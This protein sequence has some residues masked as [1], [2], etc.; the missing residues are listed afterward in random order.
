MLIFFGGRSLLNTLETSKESCFEEE[1]DKKR[2]E[3]S[4]HGDGG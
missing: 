1:E 2:R 4:V 3:A